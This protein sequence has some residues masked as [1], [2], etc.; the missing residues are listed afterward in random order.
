MKLR[1]VSHKNEKHRKHAILHNTIS[2]YLL[3]NI[4]SIHFKTNMK[5]VQ[6]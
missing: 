3:L 4:N 6:W 5:L 2:F 1:F